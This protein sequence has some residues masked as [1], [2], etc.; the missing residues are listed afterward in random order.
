MTKANENG[1]Q[2]L[3]HGQVKEGEMTEEKEAPKKLS[4]MEFVK[5][6]AL[7][8]GALAGVGALAS[9]AGPQAEVGPQGPP[10]PQGPAGPAGPSGV[11]EIEWDEEAD[12]VV[13]GG[14]TGMLGAIAAHDAGAKVILVEKQ[15]V[16][17]GDTT[18]CGGVFYAGGTSVQEAA[19]VVDERTGQ[20]DTVERTYEDW[21]K[22]NRYQADPDL[23]R[24]IVESGPSIIDW[25][26]ERGVE[27]VLFQSGTDPVKRGHTA[28]GPV[29]AGHGLAYTSVLEEEVEQRQISVYL[30]TKALEI[31]T[32][33]EDRIVGLKAK[34][35]TGEARYLGTKAVILAT[36]SNGGN[37]ELVMRYNPE[38]ITWNQTG[39]PY[40][41]GD[42]IL[43]ADK[44]RA[45][46][47]GF[48]SRIDRSSIY[49][50]HLK[51]TNELLQAQGYADWVQASP[52]AFLYVNLDGNRFVDE[53]LGYYGG[54]QIV[55]QPKSS[56]FTIFD[57]TMYDLPD[58]G[59]YA[60]AG[61]QDR[62]AEAVEK[63]LVSKAETVEELATTLGLDASS[64]KHTLDT[65]NEHA[66]RGEDPDFGRVATSLKPI[67]E[68]PFYGYQMVPAG[69]CANISLD[70]NAE[71]EVRD[72]DGWVIPGLYAQG[73]W[74]T[75]G[76][77]LDY[78]VFGGVEMPGSGCQIAA[79]MATGRIAGENAAEYAKAL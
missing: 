19:G 5:G 37:L 38:S 41:T 53:S 40:G 62:L 14:G 77:L 46:F 4:R 60:V 34:N 54:Y 13:V 35:K 15:P 51:G 67:A 75:G 36:G 69:R 65:F 6:A 27:F 21:V 29:F 39:G 26:A 17:G 61:S 16:L 12:V 33:D 10:G 31:L 24:K 78:R 47:V 55:T 66:G 52:K 45:G 23:V 74:L 28:G 32:D 30:D 48:A 68:S 8:A 63:G 2:V 9:C 59:L 72:R 71:C 3:D 22:V 11:T 44:L 25:F 1:D 42:G 18:L 79:G 20:P 56:A 49:V 76:G 73:S 50:C 43:M 7:G 57:Q 70:V 58:F 64:V